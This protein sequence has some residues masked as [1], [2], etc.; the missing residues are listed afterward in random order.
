MNYREDH[1]ALA[2]LLVRA[3]DTILACRLVNPE[4]EEKAKGMSSELYWAAEDV[5]NKPRMVIEQ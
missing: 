3:G 2:A 1:K 4:F 5:S